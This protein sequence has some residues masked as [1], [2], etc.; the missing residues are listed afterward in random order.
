MNTARQEGKETRHAVLE[1]V[2]MGL[3]E[4]LVE[5]LLEGLHRSFE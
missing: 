2:M 5:G 3:N 4:A 1:Y